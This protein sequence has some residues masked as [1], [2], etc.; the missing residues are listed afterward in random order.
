MGN[1][2][3][4][5]MARVPGAARGAKVVLPDGAVRLV[6]VPAKAAELMLEAPGHFLADARALRAGRRIAALGADEDLELGG[7]YAAFPMKRLGA[8]AAPADMAR[9]AAAVSREAAARRSATAKVA[10][11]V[12]PHDA[13]AAASV[14][15]PRLDEMAVGDAAAEAEIGELKQRISGGRRSRRPTLETILEESYAPAAAAAAAA[16]SSVRVGLSVTTAAGHFPAASV[17]RPPQ[18]Q[19]VSWC[20]QRRVLAHAAVGCFVTHHCGWALAAGVQCPSSPTRRGPTRSPTPRQATGGG[21][22]GRRWS[23]APGASD[24]RRVLRRCVDEV[25]SGPEA[26]RLRAQE[27]WRDDKAANAAVADGGSSD[28]G[29]RDFAGLISVVHRCNIIHS[30]MLNIA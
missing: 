29:M 12:A 20:E 28:R 16:A 17:R 23:P 19:A 30:Y 25:M 4:C 26:T 21:R 11:V 22:V 5:T 18:G 1:L 9:L 24:V 27:W 10:A 14:A 6:R 3:S 8:P 15:R 13:A 2:A 7:V